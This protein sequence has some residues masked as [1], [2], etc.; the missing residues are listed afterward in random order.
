MQGSI[1]RVAAVVRGEMPDR[2][3]MFDLLRNDAVINHF[4]GEALTVENAEEVVPAAYEPAIDA[5]RSMRL[6][7]REETLTLDDGRTRKIYRWTAWTE[8]TKYRDSEHYE[9]VKRAELEASDPGA[10]DDDRQTR[11]EAGLRD[12]LDPAGRFGDFLLMEGIG[13][14]GLCSI[15]AEIGL[16]EFSYC[17]VDCPDIIAE[18]MERN[19]VAIRTYSWPAGSTYRSS[20]PSARR[21]R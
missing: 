13:S 1:D 17:L 10:W 8:H 15:Y 7:G 14:P 12:Q 16:E 3:P 5:T 4:T 21:A 9:S 20:C 19:T 2:A 18:I 11:L 6:P